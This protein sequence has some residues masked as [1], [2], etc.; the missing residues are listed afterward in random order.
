VWI[1]PEAS[2]LEGDAQLIQRLRPQRNERE[3]R[4]STGPGDVDLSQR[5]LAIELSHMD[6]SVVSFCRAN[7]FIEGE[8]LAVQARRGTNARGYE[9]EHRGT[10]EKSPATMR[11]RSTPHETR[12]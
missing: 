6:G 5:H 4:Q 11:S 3:G 8:R 10:N 2:T 12:S 9:N 7:R 1:N